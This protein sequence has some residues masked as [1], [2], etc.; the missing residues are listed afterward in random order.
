MDAIDE[1]QQKGKEKKDRGPASHIVT[2]RFG[3][4]EH[5]IEVPF[6]SLS[7]V[8][9]LMIAYV[10]TCHKMQGGE[11]PVVII[12]CHGA[13]RAM[14]YREWLYTAVTRASEK[15]ILLY[16]EDALKSTLNKQKMPGSTLKQKVMAFNA[17]QDKGDSRIPTLPYSYVHAESRSRSHRHCGSDARASCQP[18]REVRRTHEPDEEEGGHA[19]G[20]GS[21]TRFAAPPYHA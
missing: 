12:I 10:V 18:S 2:V 1:G 4:A 21:S 7:E 15:C 13:H 11:S 8:G 17:A 19:R 16:S 3:D 14:L 20:A 5:G 6:G 9:S